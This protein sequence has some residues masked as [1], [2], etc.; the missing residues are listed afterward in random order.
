[1]TL[2]YSLSVYSIPLYFLYI[3][4]IGSLEYTYNIQNMVSE[5]GY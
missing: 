5:L 2:L 3:L 1:M 4:S